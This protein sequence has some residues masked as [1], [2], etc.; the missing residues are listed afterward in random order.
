MLSSQLLDAICGEIFVE[1]SPANFELVTATDVKIGGPIA[2]QRYYKAD[3]Q[4]RNNL[5]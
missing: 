5:E 3:N 4:A 1:C 2:L